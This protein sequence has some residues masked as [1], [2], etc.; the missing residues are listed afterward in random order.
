MRAHGRTSESPTAA[1]LIQSA[2]ERAT[3]A[4][5][6]VLDTLL[7]AEHALSHQDIER[8]L[9]GRQHKIDKVTLYRVLDWAQ[10][11][12]LVHKL[13]G[14]DRVWRFSATSNSDHT[15][16][17]CTDCGQIYCLENLTPA[18]ALNL[19]EGFE[20]LHADV[21]VQGLCPRCSR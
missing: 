19:P 2:G 10:N 14:E 12:G 8:I 13:T 21:A 17:N 7:A 4:R 3:Q 9:A 6:A 15:H 18:V 5:I 11:Q 16:F 20:L 1:N